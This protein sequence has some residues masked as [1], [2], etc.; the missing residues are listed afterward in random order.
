VHSLFFSVAALVVLAA[1]Q[2]DNA[3]CAN[4]GG[5]Y[6]AAVQAV[7][8]A[9]KSYGKCVAESNEKNECAAEMQALDDA[10]DNFLDALDDAKDCK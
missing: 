7:A 9:W 1:P 4:A 8:E 3:D 10:H 5:R 2:P 6:R